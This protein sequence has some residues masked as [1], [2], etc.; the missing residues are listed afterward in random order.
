MTYF[1]L[2]PFNSKLPEININY[3]AR[4]P[5]YNPTINDVFTCTSM[6]GEEDLSQRKMCSWWHENDYLSRMF[7]SEKNPL[8]ID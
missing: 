1:F 2:K 3:V 8:K 6:R 4:T 5:K 7:R